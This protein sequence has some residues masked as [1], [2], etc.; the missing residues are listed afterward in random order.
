M[1][2]MVEM[3]EDSKRLWSAIV[4][5][6]GTR[7]DGNDDTNGTRTMSRNETR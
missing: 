6:P 7:G 1:R 2:L 4:G 3:R 5:G